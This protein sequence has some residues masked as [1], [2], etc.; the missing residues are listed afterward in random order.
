MCAMQAETAT[1]IHDL[2]VVKPDDILPPQAWGLYLGQH[3]DVWSD[4]I[5]SFDYVTLECLI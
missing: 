2:A 1:A 3:Q 5:L 4:Q